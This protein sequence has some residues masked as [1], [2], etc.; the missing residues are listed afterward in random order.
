MCQVKLYINKQNRQSTMLE[1]FTEIKY[2]LRRKFVQLAAKVAT[3]Q[4][5]SA[6]AYFR[7]DSKDLKF[8]QYYSKYLPKLTMI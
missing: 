5:M 3:K 1:F 8:F 6:C 2:C 4:T 7:L